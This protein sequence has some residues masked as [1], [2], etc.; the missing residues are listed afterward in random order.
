MIPRRSVFHKGRV[1]GP[2]R[3]RSR[4]D[5]MDETLLILIEKCAV[6]ARSASDIEPAMSFLTAESD[7]G[8]GGQAEEIGDLF[9][10]LRLKKNAAFAVTA[11]STFLAF[12]S[13]H[14]QVPDAGLWPQ[15]VEGKRWTSKPRLLGTSRDLPPY[16][17]RV[18]SNIRVQKILCVLCVCGDIFRVTGRPV[19]LCT[20]SLHQTPSYRP[21]SPQPKQQS[22]PPHP[23]P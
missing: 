2:Q 8:L 18:Y 14:P 17:E 13:F 11:L 3:A 10:F 5:L 16:L 4:F 20:E 12:K 23:L 19:P 9:D 1:K 7:E 15:P 21:R 22:P 6:A